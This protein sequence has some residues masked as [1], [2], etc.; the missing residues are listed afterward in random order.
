ML[1]CVRGVGA[2]EVLDL[3]MQTRT[4]MDAAGPTQRSVLWCQS[5][6]ALLRRQDLPYPF[7]PHHPERLLT[8][9][10]EGCLVDD[11]RW[12]EVSLSRCLAFAVESLCA[13]ACTDA[14]FSV[15]DCRPQVER[16]GS[17]ARV[18]SAS[19]TRQCRGA[20]H[21]YLL[22]RDHCSGVNS[23]RPA[24]CWHRVSVHHEDRCMSN[25]WLAEDEPPQRPR[26]LLIRRAQCSLACLDTPR[27][28]SH[29]S[30]RA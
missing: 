25:T 9:I 20:C 22:R 23:Y 21:H 13:V 4:S 11:T 7:V 8:F 28:A 10:P 3:R 1:H 6:L 30:V 5:L 26:R 15:V 16:L 27:R 19:A 24:V 29:A 17:N 12:T 18:N 14:C 2:S